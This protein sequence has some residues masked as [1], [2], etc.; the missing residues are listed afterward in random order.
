MT[1]QSL[2]HKKPARDKCCSL[3]LVRRLVPIGDWQIICCSLEII[4]ILN[5]NAN[6]LAAKVRKLADTAQAG[7]PATPWR[8]LSSS[9][10]YSFDVRSHRAGSC[11]MPAAEAAWSNS[12]F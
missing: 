3:V 12:H 1:F 11:S 6:L 10:M 9:S 7:I 5:G 4:V 2:S 8:S